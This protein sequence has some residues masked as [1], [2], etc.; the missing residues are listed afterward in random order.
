[1]ASLIISLIAGLIGTAYF[2]YGRKQSRSIAMWAGAGLCV[3]PYFVGN[4][5]WALQLL[6]GIVLALLPLL[7]QE[8]SRL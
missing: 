1:M 8:E 3:Y 2:I 4:L 6:L 7:I 5:H